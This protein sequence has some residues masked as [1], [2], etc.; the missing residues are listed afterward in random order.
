MVLKIV[1]Q[2]INEGFTINFW[3]MRRLIVHIL[4]LWVIRIPMTQVSYLMSGITI[5]Y[6]YFVLLSRYGYWWVH[7]SNCRESEVT[8][9]KDSKQAVLFLFGV[10]VWQTEWNTLLM[11]FVTVYW[12]SCRNIIMVDRVRR[13]PRQGNL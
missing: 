11:R 4:H 6:V 2:R 13:S 5:N 9:S 3:I 7:K 12:L 8:S 10:K 1:W